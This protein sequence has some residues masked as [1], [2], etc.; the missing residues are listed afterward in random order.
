MSFLSF[1]YQIKEDHDRYLELKRL[2][3][4]YENKRIQMVKFYESVKSAQEVSIDDIPLPNAPMEQSNVTSINTSN[5]SVINQPQSILKKHNLSSQI[6]TQRNPPGVPPGP[7]P[8]LSD[9]EDESDDE[10]NDNNEKEKNRRIRFCDEQTEDKEAD[11]NEFLKEIEQVEKAA[12]DPATT[13]SIQSL[14]NLPPQPN[15]IEVPSHGAA[16]PPTP[17]LQA[18]SQTSV[19]PLFMFRPPMGSV[20]PPSGMRLIQPQPG[21]MVPNRPPIVPNPQLRPGMPLP[22]MPPPQQLPARLQQKIQATSTMTASSLT[23]DGKKTGYITD[24]ATIEAKP[25][26]RNLSAD[27]TRFTPVALRVKREDKLVK[28]HTKSGK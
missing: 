23:K 14:T 15:Q 22:R 16:I 5:Q 27:A 19:P 4:D 26:L 18:P 3:A 25:Q 21:G 8:V 12:R 2:E 20:P 24:R 7:P 1:E 17:S 6:C 13:Q 11:I 28:K 10:S 9:V